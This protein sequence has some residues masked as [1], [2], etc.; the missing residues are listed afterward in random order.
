MK[1]AK[2]SG[3]L[4]YYVTKAAVAL[5]DWLYVSCSG[6]DGPTRLLVFDLMSA[7][8][9]LCSQQIRET[10]IPRLAVGSILRAD[11]HRHKRRDEKHAPLF[12]SKALVFQGR[13]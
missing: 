7:A 12:Q 4:K 9:G 8:G 11:V 13:H 2:E 3:S 10:R 6:I 5:D 1:I